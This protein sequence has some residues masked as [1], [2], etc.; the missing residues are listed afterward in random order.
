MCINLETKLIKCCDDNLHNEMK[1]LIIG[2][3][4]E[5]GNTIINII[6]FSFLVWFSTIVNPKSLGNPNAKEGRICSFIKY[7]TPRMYK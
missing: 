7:M 2:L 5:N 6:F 1:S 4:T 3:K